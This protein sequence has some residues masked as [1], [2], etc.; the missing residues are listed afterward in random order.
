[1]SKEDILKLMQNYVLQ[2]KAMSERGLIIKEELE[3]MNE[4]D[5]KWYEENFSKWLKENNL[6]QR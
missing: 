5:S 1:M 6:L 2:L 4:A 3:K